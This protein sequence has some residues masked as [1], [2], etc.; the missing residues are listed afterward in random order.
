VSNQQFF[1]QKGGKMKNKTYF[2]LVIFLT[3][4]SMTLTGCSQPKT[5]DAKEVISNEKVEKW[6]LLWISDSSGWGV[7]D[8]YA[9]YVAEDLG[10]EIDVNDQWMGHLAAGEVLASLNGEPNPN[11][12]LVRM[13]EYIQEAEI[14]VFYGNPNLSL[15]TQ[16]PH[17]QPCSSLPARLPF[18]HRS[19]IDLRKAVLDWNMPKGII[20]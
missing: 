8:I 9:G 12:N 7:V 13:A 6:D 19:I 20:T 15:S 17:P 11:M 14:I 2:R 10:I 18:N 4:I 3:I 1:I 16:P 5:I